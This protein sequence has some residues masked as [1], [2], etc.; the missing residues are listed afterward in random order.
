MAAAEVGCSPAPAKCTLHRRAHDAGSSLSLCAQRSVG[1]AAVPIGSHPALPP[2]PHTHPRAPRPCPACPADQ[3]LTRHFVTSLALCPFARTGWCGVS[4]AGGGGAGLDPQEGGGGARQGVAA[5]RGQALHLMQTI[6]DPGSIHPYVCWQPHTG[7]PCAG[8]PAGHAAGRGA[9]SG[10]GS[11]RQAD[12][13]GAEGCGA[14][15]GRATLGG[16]VG[17][18]GRGRPAAGTL[19]LARTASTSGPALAPAAACCARVPGGGGE[20]GG[21][22]LAGPLRYGLHLRA[23]YTL[24]CFAR[25]FGGDVLQSGRSACF[26]QVSCLIFGCMNVGF[27]QDPNLC[28]LCCCW[29]WR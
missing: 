29:R 26:V 28:D 19:G 8:T 13:E 4:R 14:A 20:D 3:L 11:G 10:S 22:G 7:R 5:P 2:P 16:A 6:T 27:A 9:P 17:G 1:L 15:C 18:L 25:D 12:A 21:S 23:A 24:A